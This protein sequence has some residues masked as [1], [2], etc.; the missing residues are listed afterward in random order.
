MAIGEWND[1]RNVAN[2]QQA[3]KSLEFRQHSTN[4]FN[5]LNGYDHHYSALWPGWT[6]TFTS[7][8]WVYLGNTWDSQALYMV[9]DIGWNR[10]N[11]YAFVQTLTGTGRVRIQVLDEF[12]VHVMYIPD[13]A[14]ALVS[15]TGFNRFG[16][17]NPVGTITPDKLYHLRFQARVASGGNSMTVRLWVLWFT[18]SGET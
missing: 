16:V 3:V 14:G 18:H 10:L 4:L 9:D 11:G 8:S 1:N 17:T 12:D 13:V 15:G 2:W 6:T 7:T 5:L